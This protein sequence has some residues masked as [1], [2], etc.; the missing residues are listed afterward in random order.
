MVSACFERRMFG[1]PE[2]SSSSLGSF[3]QRGVSESR[4]EQCN[5]DLRVMESPTTRIRALTREQNG[6][7]LTFAVRIVPWSEYAM[8]SEENGVGLLQFPPASVRFP[9]LEWDRTSLN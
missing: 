7:Q 4:H 8:V 3:G 2:P 5:A 1:G 9:R 6:S